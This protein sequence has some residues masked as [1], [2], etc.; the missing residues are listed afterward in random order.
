MTQPAVDPSTMRA[1]YDRLIAL[2]RE[3]HG[4]GLHETA[5][6]ALCAALHAAQSASDRVSVAQVADEARE[7]I[8]WID[9]HMPDHRIS[10][11]SASR[12]DHPG[13]YAMLERQAGTITRMLE[14]GAGESR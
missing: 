11:A 6:H 1:L 2:S 5:Y 14:R 10:T 9:T 7:Q 8:N 3:A 13:V 12:H 4:L